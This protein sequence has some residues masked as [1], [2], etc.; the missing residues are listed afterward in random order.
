MPPLPPP[1]CPVRPSSRPPLTQRWSTATLN[2]VRGP[3][4]INPSKQAK[5]PAYV[6]SGK[7]HVDLCTITERPS[8]LD[9]IA[10]VRVC[11][12][13]RIAWAGAAFSIGTA[14]L[15]Y[16]SNGVRIFHLVPFFCFV[17]CV[18]NRGKAVAR[19]EGFARVCHANLLQVLR[20][21]YVFCSLEDFT[22]CCY[23]FTAACAL[24]ACWG[25]SEKKIYRRDGDFVHN[26]DRLHSIK[27]EPSRPAISPLRGP[28]GH[29]SQRLRQGHERYRA[30]AGVLR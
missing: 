19:D 14:G 25:R 30:R 12:R 20:S 11:M 9:Y 23:A 24:V 5:N 16:P 27:R 2:D 22:A 17:F 6:D 3:A 4:L 8:F 18:S 29:D 15:Y 21:M 7:L 1:P 10:G 13:W 26:G 28:H